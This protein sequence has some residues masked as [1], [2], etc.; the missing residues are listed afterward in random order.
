MSPKTF[1]ISINVILVVCFVF[2]EL[3]FATSLLSQIFLSKANSL[4]KSYRWRKAQIFYQAAVN[5]SPHDSRFSAGYGDFFLRQSAFRKNKV[6]Y[7]KDALKLYKRASRLA[8]HN[9][10]YLLTLAQIQ[11]RL[12]N[13]DKKAFKNELN[14]A[15][16]NLQQALNLDPNGVN[17][18]Y[19]A[20]YVYVS[21]WSDLH[22]DWKALAKK[23]L[24]YALSNSPWYS[25]NIYAYI[26][27]Q[28]ADF[29]FM[30][31][32]TPADL[33]NQLRLYDFLM[34]NE[35][36]SLYQQ[37]RQAIKFYRQSQL[38]KKQ[39]IQQEKQIERISR[40]KQEAL[41]KEEKPTFFIENND[42]QGSSEDG[43]K[44][45]GGKMY[46]EGT[47]EG[48]IW[49]PAGDFK[50]VITARG[51]PAEGIFP[52][53]VVELDGELIGENFI[54]SPQWKEYAFKINAA[55]SE[56]GIKVLSISYI[57]DRV[58]SQHQNRNLFIKQA[59]VIKDE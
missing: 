55:E 13:I 38:G 4:D 48:V 33:A 51:K 58:W 5:V 52:Y 21:L 45:Q 57:N 20:G 28:T 41:A 36:T 35:L 59:K 43:E 17:T 34:K 3:F 56:A 1:R 37:Q 9:V 7:F 8:P 53:M 32:V 29:L 54:N 14:S 24:R 40:L 11:A 46:E 15:L 23:R 6:K 25:K 47:L 30:Q 44:Y 16:F 22:E 2:F 18:A 26:W 12:Y 19:V 42:W 31:D 39:K 27:K 49:L 50:I 10:S